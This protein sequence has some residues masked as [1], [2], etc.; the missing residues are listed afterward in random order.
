MKEDEAPSSNLPVHLSGHHRETVSQILHHPVSHNIEWRAVVLLLQAVAQVK[1]THNGRLLV[2]LGDETETLEPP[3][4]K[5][6]D[7]QQVVDLRR[8][9]RGVLATR[10]DA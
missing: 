3:R 1:G 10:I 5:G 4:P 2:T 7:S 9:L 6:I 8:M